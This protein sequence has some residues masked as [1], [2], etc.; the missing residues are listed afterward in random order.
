MFSAFEMEYV[1][2]AELHTDNLRDRAKQWLQLKTNMTCLFCLR[3][4]PEHVLT[5][6]HAI[7][8]CCV[9]IFGSAISGAEL[10]FSVSS[11]ILCN[12]KGSLIARVHPPTAGV[13]I[14]SIDGGGIRGVVPLEFLGL[15]QEVIG[16][17][18]Q[19]QSLID[20]AVGT[21]SGESV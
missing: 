15:L 8:D 20:L 4:K 18:C 6:E 19:I 12:T 21:S 7:C 10:H 9:K 3:R 1:T 14:L 16:P 11:C 17:E 5:C 2:S 13:R